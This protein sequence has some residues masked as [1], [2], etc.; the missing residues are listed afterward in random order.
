MPSRIAVIGM[1][2]FGREVAVS[3]TQNG[4]AVLAI[5]TDAEV[6]EAMKERVTRAIR[7]DSTDEVALYEAKI[8]ELPVVI[9]A[10]GMQH[11]ENSIITTALLKQLEIPRIIARATNPLHERILHQVGA[12]E[13][14]NP[15]QDSAR[16]LAYQIA[17][18]GLRDV[19]SLAKNVV[20]AEVPVPPSFV[21]KTLADVDVRRRYGIT[22][23]GVQRVEASP[24]ALE[25][26]DESRFARKVAAARLLDQDR[27]LILNISP[28]ADVF[29][30]DDTLVVIG[31]EEDVNKLSGLA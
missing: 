19:L 24:A 31:K 6:I 29:L 14:V 28:T 7:L 3:L 27:Q 11:I 1:G 30:E 18:P 26:Q 4:F 12:T 17:R 23:I 15:E 2:I 5:D 13:V 25:A 9:N 10:I 22:V 20:V 16:K 8:D 21:G